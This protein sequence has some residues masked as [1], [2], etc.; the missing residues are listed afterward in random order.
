MTATDVTYRYD[1]TLAAEQLRALSDAF[2]IYGVRRIHV[3]EGRRAI[4]V[5]YDATRMNNDV[6]AAILR[7]CG[8]AVGEKVETTSPAAS[9]PAATPAPAAV[10]A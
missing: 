3:D 2:D 5:E 9:G 7:R 8:I 1:G 4:T 10:K 6:V